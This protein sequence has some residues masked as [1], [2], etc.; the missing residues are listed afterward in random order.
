MYT[1]DDFHTGSR[2]QLHPA[3]DLWMSGA[4]Y[5]NVAHVGRKLLHILLDNNKTVKVSPD[6]IGEII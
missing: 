5:G 1:I 3:T 2:V 4:R 6:N